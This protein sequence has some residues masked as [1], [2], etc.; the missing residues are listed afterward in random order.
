MPVIK[1]FFIHY[2]HLKQFLKKS[3][4]VIQESTARTFPT[5]SRNLEF[6]N[7]TASDLYNFLMF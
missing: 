7:I 3:L 2:Y 1:N 4:S 5:E 6:F